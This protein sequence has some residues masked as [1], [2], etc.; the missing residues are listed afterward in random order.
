MVERP[1][2]ETV[3][4]LGK[5]S[6]PRDRVSVGSGDRDKIRIEE[7]KIRPRHHLR[8][9]GGD[10]DGRDR[11]IALRDQADTP[12]KILSR[13]RQTDVVT[14]RAIAVDERDENPS[15]IRSPDREVGRIGRGEGNRDGD[16]RLG[17]GRGDDTKERDAGAQKP[18]ESDSSRRMFPVVVV[19]QHHTWCE[20]GYRVVRC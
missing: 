9:A 14:P 15:R 1:H 18:A 7:P 4:S 11:E 19:V 2:A 6:C 10:D 3:R 20:V 8:S 5:H 13:A 12:V 16:R 17:A